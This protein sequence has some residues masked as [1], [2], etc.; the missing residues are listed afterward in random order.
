MPY[1]EEPFVLGPKA[2]ELRRSIYTDIDLLHR[3]SAALVIGCD[4]VATAKR[5]ATE[6]S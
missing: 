3:L 6:V 4:S 5:A 2:R 1:C